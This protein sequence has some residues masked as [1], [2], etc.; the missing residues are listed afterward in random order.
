MVTS[1]TAH[2]PS[3]C[4]L[5]APVDLLYV[6]LFSAFAQTVRLGFALA[7]D[8]KLPP[9]LRRLPAVLTRLTP[10][11]IALSALGS[12]RLHTMSAGAL[13]SWLESRGLGLSEQLRSS[14]PL[15]PGL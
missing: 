9:P 10:P 11:A 1:R 6:K 7:F 4:L 15:L 5:F 3:L 13:S 2:T 12:S 14:C 8:L